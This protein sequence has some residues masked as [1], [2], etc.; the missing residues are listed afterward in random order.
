MGKN[1]IIFGTDIGP[2]VHIDNRRKDILVLGK[3]PK[4]R[5]H[6]TTRAEAVYPI[7]FTE[8]QKRFCWVYTIIDVTVSY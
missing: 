5:L 6:N 2:S 1:I 3:R 7:N 8:S 4:Q